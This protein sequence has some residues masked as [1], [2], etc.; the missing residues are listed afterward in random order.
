MDQS[1]LGAVRRRLRGGVGLT[2]SVSPV[3]PLPPP[4]PPLGSE[5]DMRPRGAS[6]GKRSSH[7][8]WLLILA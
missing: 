2:P 4:V 7:A 1:V 3:M 8:L 6:A 5:V